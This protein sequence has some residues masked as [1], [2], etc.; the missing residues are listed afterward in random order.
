MKKIVSCLRNSHE[1]ASMC[2]GQNGASN[3]ASHE[4]IPTIVKAENDIVLP[5]NNGIEASKTTIITTLN[6][7]KLDVSSPNKSELVSTTI[8]VLIDDKIDS[9]LPSPGETSTKTIS[10]TATVTHS[11]INFQTNG[12]TTETVATLVSSSKSLEEQDRTNV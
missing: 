1:I 3:G 11:P 2:R 6:P 8:D 9:H 5:S 7:D 4:A 12:K 10:T